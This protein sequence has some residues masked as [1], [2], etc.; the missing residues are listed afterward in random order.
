MTTIDYCMFAL[1]LCIA[2]FW[3]WAAGYRVATKDR[4]DEQEELPPPTN[5]QLRE[6]LRRMP[7]NDHSNFRN[8]GGDNG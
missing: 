3:G 4:E 5:E 8:K 7:M 6:A 2:F 1:L